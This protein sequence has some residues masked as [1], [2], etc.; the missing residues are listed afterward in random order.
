M[1]FIKRSATAPEAERNPDNG[2]VTN[3]SALSSADDGA[4]WSAARA[5]GGHAEAV[6]ALAA[7]LGF[8]QK[9]A[10]ATEALA[11]GLQ[12]EPMVAEQVVRA[13][14]LTSAAEAGASL[15][16]MAEVS[17]HANPDVLR[18]YVRRADLFKDH[19]GAA[20]L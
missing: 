13:G 14:F 1:P 12:I 9:L 17:R 2:L 5:L 18:G 11:Q 20:F 16:K 4:R 7:A 3:I 6:A 19:A 8:E 10:K 15:L